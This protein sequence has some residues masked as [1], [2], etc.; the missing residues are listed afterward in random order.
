MWPDEASLEDE[1]ESL[2]EV[3][4]SSEGKAGL[5][6]G[7]LLRAGGDWSGSG[8]TEC[9]G[10]EGER[11]TT[12]QGGGG[13]ANGG[14]RDEWERMASEEQVGVIQEVVVCP[15]DTDSASQYL[16]LP[17]QYRPSESQGGYSATRGSR[18]LS[19]CYLDIKIVRTCQLNLLIIRNPSDPPL[20]SLP[21]T[22]GRRRPKISLEFA[23]NPSGGVSRRCD[24]TPCEFF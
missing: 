3:V 24:V 10:D 5:R 13:L 9:S 18:T 12:A 19:D 11:I 17:L 6:F 16:A 15:G 2:N 8:A 14:A 1:G 22:R 20:L 23:S 21:D 4:E 7:D